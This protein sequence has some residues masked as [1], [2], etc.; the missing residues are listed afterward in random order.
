MNP[1]L[2]LP[3]NGGFLRPLVEADVHQGYVDG[4]N[5]PLVNRYLDGVKASVQTA[6]SVRDFVAADRLS[7]SSVLWGVWTD[8][9]PRHV[10]TVRLHGIERRHGTAHIGI[11]LFDQRCWGRGLG[12][13]AIAAAT[14]WAID[15]L[16]LRWIEAGAYEANLASQ[17]AFLSAGYAGVFD[18]PG[19]Y[20]FEGVPTTVKV[21]AARA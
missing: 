9:S 11:C 10:G 19:K 6:G 12:S 20:L 1:E 18:I 15:A 16:G 3:I 13:A 4:L 2:A 7:P 17:R 21:Y 8:E 5:D 14:R